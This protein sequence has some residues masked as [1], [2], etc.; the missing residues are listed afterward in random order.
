[1]PDN[2]L[3]GLK[4]LLS[5]KY[6]IQLTSTLEEVVVSW[7]FNCDVVIR[8]LVQLEYMYLG[9]FDTVRIFNASENKGVVIREIERIIQSHPFYFNRNLKKEYS[10][11]KIQ[12]VRANRLNRWGSMN[13]ESSEL[14]V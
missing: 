11:R 6:M 5:D 2:L 8:S 4:N 9:S 1:M 12:H 14:L 13:V 7:E 10:T 3:Q